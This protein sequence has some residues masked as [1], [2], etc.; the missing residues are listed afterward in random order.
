MSECDS[1]PALGWR[2]TT[3]GDLLA[4]RCER[5]SNGDPLLSVTAARGVVLQTQAGRRDISNADKS[6]YWRVYPADIAY[7]SMRMWQGVSGRSDYFGIVSPAYTVCAPRSSCDSSFVAHLLKH[8]PSIATFKN[9]S[10]GLVSDTWSLKYGAFA[11]IRTSVP[12]AVAEQRLIAEV[13]D[14]IDA[15]IRSSERVVAKL[16]QI[17]HGFLQDFLTR[18]VDDNGTLRDAGRTPGQFAPTPLGLLPRSWDT[19]RAA[20][21]CERVSVGVVNSATH[22][23]VNVGVP[24]IRSQNV[25]PN[26]IDCDD[27]LHVTERFNRL[28]GHSALRSGD[29]VIVRTGYPGTA[30]V[31][32]QALDGSNCFSLVIARTGPGLDPH[33]LACYLNSPPGKVSVARTHSGALSTT[34]TS[35]R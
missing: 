32:P 6:A 9:R 18:G 35:A 12:I 4:Q 26:R 28:H 34:S 14:G 15:A 29:V 3:F 2:N 8:P 23:Y 10:Q 31:V 11:A 22:A 21:Q 19:P 20:E 1:P 13:L 7:N 30:A 17:A 16:E 27:M 25:R 33:F 5:G 24:F